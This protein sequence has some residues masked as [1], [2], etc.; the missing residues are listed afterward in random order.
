MRP[1]KL[2]DREKT[3]TSSIVPPAEQLEPAW[4]FAFQA[5]KL[6]VRAKTSSVSI[7]CLADLEELG[8]TI[9]RRHYLG[10]LAGRHCY[11][12][13]LDEG[14]DPPAG[15]DFQ[16]LRQVYGLV[17]EDLFALAGRALQIVE[18]DKTNQ[19]CG[20]CGSRTGMS[21]TERAKK[22]PR[23]GLL[24]FPRLSPAIIVLVQ[25]HH[26]L[27]LARP[28]HFPPG[29]YSVIAG[30]VEPGETLEEAVVR[31]VREEVGLAIKDIRYFGSQ[32]WP[33]PHSLMIGFTA[34]YAGGEISLDDTEMEDAGWFRADSLP[35]LPGEI[36]IARKLIDWFLAKQG[37]SEG[38]NGEKPG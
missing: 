32:P 5:D 20:R 16:G 7:P 22:C 11:A 1:G 38:S 15:M 9:T 17:D 3:F 30:F 27:L 19:Y 14:N 34:T 29:L 8:L 31:E 23:C 10:Q 4:W 25:R 35:T 24:A 36:S 18:W 2:A 12:V 6:L 26:E 21:E 37:A 33:F 28:Y 13:E